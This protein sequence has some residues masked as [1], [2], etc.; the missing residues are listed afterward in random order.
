[1]L[2]R[3]ESVQLDGSISKCI[4][5]NYKHNE[6][7]SKCISEDYDSFLEKLIQFQLNWVVQI[8]FLL[9]NKHIVYTVNVSRIATNYNEHRELQF[10]MEEDFR[11]DKIQ[12]EGQCLKL[13][14]K[15][16]KPPNIQTFLC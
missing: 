6:Q 4:S 15:K 7:Q 1:M 3:S 5:H 12:M 2:T 11:Y 16:M 14:L 9:G 8:I 10:P 13:I